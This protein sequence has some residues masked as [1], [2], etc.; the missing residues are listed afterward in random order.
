MRAARSNS[1]EA[2][3]GTGVVL[4]RVTAHSAASRSAVACA[5]AGPTDASPPRSAMKN[6]GFDPIRRANLQVSALRFGAEP[7]FSAR[8]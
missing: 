6:P 3:H 8:S 4:R 7:T 1:S 2:A 5:T